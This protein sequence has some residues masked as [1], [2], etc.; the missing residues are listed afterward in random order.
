MLILD[1]TWKTTGIRWPRVQVLHKLN[2][3]F[4]VQVIFG[5]SGCPELFWQSI[6]SIH[7]TCSY[8]GLISDEIIYSILYCRHTSH[9]AEPNSSRS[10]ILATAHYWVAREQNY[11]MFIFSYSV[12]SISAAASLGVFLRI[13]SMA[14]AAT[15]G[16]RVK[17]LEEED[18]ETEW[19]CSV[20]TAL[21][22][23]DDW[24]RSLNFCFNPAQLN[25]LKILV[26]GFS[27]SPYVYKMISLKPLSLINTTLE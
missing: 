24:S 1:S 11:L 27:Q 20:D 22:E 10:Q 8:Y 25:I 4:L 13:A 15:Q 21:Q 9:C 3:V 7:P 6:F 2:L 19:R 12:S 23:S 26:N 16:Q 17:S 18:K 5:C 14:S